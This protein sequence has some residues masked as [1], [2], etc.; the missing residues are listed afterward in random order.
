[1][2]FVIICF[3]LALAG[4]GAPPPPA[5]NNAP[6]AE[7]AGLVAGAP[8]RC[9]GTTQSEGFRSVNRNTLILRR[10]KWVWINQLKDNCGGIGQWDALITEP[11]GTQ[12]CEGDLI[13]SFDPV[14]RIPGATCQLG[15]FI[16]YSRP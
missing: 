8:E 7:I 13:R 12:Y 10:G 9:V 11:L 5:P 4:C 15:A 2:R 16:P 1:M 14:S 3:V 6:I